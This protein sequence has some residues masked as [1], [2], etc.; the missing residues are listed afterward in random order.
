[1]TITPQHL[2]ALLPLLIVG[3]T[4]VVVML[5]IAWRRNHFFNA[6]LSVV[7]L[8]VAL[9]SLWFVGHAGA[10]DVTP[11]MRVDGYAMLYTGLVLLASLATCTF[12]YPWLEGYSDNKEEFYLLVLI[13]ALGGIL[14][15]NANHMASLFLGI[16][17]ISL[18]LFGL[19][20]YAFRQKRSLEASIKYTILSAAASSFLLF[21]I[22]LVYAQSGDL[23]FVAIGKNLGEGVLHEP[24][25][26]AGL[27]LMIVGLGF[28]L[29]LVPFHLWTPDVY[30]GAPAPVSTFLATASKIA[31]FGVLM[32]L[33]LYAPV[34]NS[35][36]VRVVL[37]VIAFVSIIFGNLMALSQTNIKRLL[38]YSSIAHLGYLMVALIALR[39][40]QMSM[41]SVGVYLAGYLFSS[42]GA[43]GVVS[44]MSSPYRGPDAE[45]LYS[46][47]GLFW[48]R[49]ILS[50][51]M[52]VMM[53]SLAGIPMT[54]GF[55]GKF[56]ILAVGVQANLW[57]LTGAVV[58]GS[59][60]GLYYYLRVAVS[61]Y[62]NAPQQLNRDAPSNWAYSAGGIVV[63][64]S[65]LLVLVLGI[66]PQPLI[67]IVQLA[68]P[69]M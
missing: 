7:G 50:A 33:F 15:A 27:G 17:L 38:G 41:E 47:R 9:L 49:P 59:A 66:Y 67:S 36:A 42:L 58:V 65:A 24:L 54:L 55:I 18:P 10:M 45:S 32:R 60:I 62:L 19:V 63:L 64:I 31:I 34:G 28:K 6:T 11:L 25:L 23:S 39:G 26:L 68:L 44:L 21:G 22:A 20:G 40:G 51:V 53:L 61:L 12:A 48:H 37:G 13:A 69:M 8:N 52:T 3:L 5:S 4:V 56:Y 2:I 30:Q 16:E 35:E 14:L 1:M 29:S 57:W 46:Y 43:F